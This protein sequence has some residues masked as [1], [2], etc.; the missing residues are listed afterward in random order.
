MVN[1][2]KLWPLGFYFVAL[3]VLYLSSG[4]I[5]SGYHMMEDHEIMVN[6]RL[7]HQMDVFNYFSKVWNDSG[8]R[9]SRGLNV[10]MA[11]FSALFGSKWWM[12]HTMVV[13]TLALAMTQFQ[14][15]GQ[16][17]GVPL[18][19]SVILPFML[20]AG[21]ATEVMTRLATIEGASLLISGAMLNRIAHGRFG[22]LTLAMVLALFF[23]KESFVLLGPFIVAFAYLIAC[24]HVNDPSEGRHEFKRFAVGVCAICLLFAVA[25]FITDVVD[26]EAD[27]VLSRPDRMLT[28]IGAYYSHIVAKRWWEATMIPYVILFFAGLLAAAVKL[29]RR[30]WLF[31]GISVGTIVSQFLLLVSVGFSGRYMIPSLIVL[32]VVF[33]VVL[34][35]VCAPRSASRVLSLG[36]VFA[37]SAQGVHSERMISE[38]V[39]SG[40]AIRETVLH[41]ARLCPAKCRVLF[42]GDPL[43]NMEM[44]QAMTVYISMESQRKN[45]T[46]SILPAETDLNRFVQ[47]SN[48]LD[49]NSVARFEQGFSDHYGDKLVSGCDGPFEVVLGI[50]EGVDIFAA[51]EDVVWDKKNYSAGC[52][53]YSFHAGWPAN[54]N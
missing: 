24:S 14:A 39:D 20:I 52:F 37:L 30:H 45:V 31:V 50:G 25:F 17:L 21:S 40:K 9:I 10:Y 16:R 32:F 4:L 5:H 51:C 11:V 3:A 33:T 48:V 49:K 22:G 19:M 2:T 18:V 54:E 12:W 42:V 46:V 41:V 35:S 53:W 13:A 7:F 27:Y 29:D 47:L 6:H 1:V 44:F 28:N 34:A 26:T 15:L 43:L 36:F 38:Y 23:M 8:N